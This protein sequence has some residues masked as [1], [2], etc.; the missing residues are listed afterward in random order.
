MPQHHYAHKVDFIGRFESLNEDFQR[1][2]K[3]INVYSDLPHLGQ[4]PK[5]DRSKYSYSMQMQEKVVSLY[6]RDFELF[7]YSPKELPS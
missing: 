5:I 4:K 3:R 1:V 2:C 7:G 6:Q